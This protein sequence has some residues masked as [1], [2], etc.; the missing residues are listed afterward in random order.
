M[1]GKDMKDS[2]LHFLSREPK[3]HGLTLFLILLCGEIFLLGPLAHAEGGW[4]SIINGV[5]YSAL[6]LMGVLA[7]TPNTIIRLISCIIIAL[8]IVMRWAANLTGSPGIYLWNL[9]F[10]L[11]SCLTFLM[12]VLSQVR[13]ET[14]VT[15]HKIRGAVVAFLLMALAFAFLYNMTELLQPGSFTL[16]VHK[17]RIHPYRL[18][19]FLYFSI[20]TITTV[21]FGDITAVGSFARSLVMVESIIGVL[22]PPVLIGVLVALHTDWLRDRSGRQD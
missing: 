2:I 8:A 17:E 5:M 3:D 9:V 21:G 19:S 13:R 4:V 14:P 22:Y 15:E 6:L 10:S 7:L 11:I 12:L 1:P 18:D 20:S 16:F